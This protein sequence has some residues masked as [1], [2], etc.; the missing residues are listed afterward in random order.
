[1]KKPS[2]FLINSNLTT[3]SDDP[4][5][6][7]EKY[8]EFLKE[9]EIA[10]VIE[11][12]VNLSNKNG[13][14]SWICSNDPGDSHLE[15]LKFAASYCDLEHF[16]DHRNQNVTVDIKSPEPFKLIKL[17]DL[18]GIGNPSAVRDLL[19]ETWSPIAEKLASVVEPEPVKEK[20]KVE[21][22]KEK[23]E[24]PKKEEI[25]PDK[26]EE[27]KDEPV[28]EKEEKKRDDEEDQKDVDLD[29]VDINVGRLR[30]LRD[31]HMFI[32]D[33]RLKTAEYLNFIGPDEPGETP[34]ASKVLPKAIKFITSS[35]LK[36]RVGNKSYPIVVYFMDGKQ[37]DALRLELKSAERPNFILGAIDKNFFEEDEPFAEMQ[38]KVGAKSIGIDPILA[39][40]MN[41]AWL[42][43]TSDV[44]GNPVSAIQ[45]NTYVPLNFFRLLNKKQRPIQIYIGG[46]PEGAGYA[47]TI[48]VLASEHE[49]S[50]FVKLMRQ[51]K[52]PSLFY[53]R[54]SAN[55]DID[56]AFKTSDPEEFT[57]SNV[58][59]LKGEF[60][61]KA[62][63]KNAGKKIKTQI[64]QLHVFAQ[65]VLGNKTKSAGTFLKGRYT[66]GTHIVQF[67]A[68]MDT[69]FVWGSTTQHVKVDT[70]EIMKAMP[71]VKQ[72]I[73]SYL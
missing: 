71:F 67:N 45:A 38:L 37:A 19:H 21:P 43:A 29:V 4:K 33:P 35:R 60:D 61:P 12:S 51:F 40:E 44:S 28:V 73:T 55:S 20:P 7:A 9:D 13:I 52:M 1:M 30:S 57:P 23:K 54:M 72:V 36:H 6:G 62:E 26:K 10:E 2:L 31:P 70:K 18:I 59:I 66:V 27:T 3:Q 5:E 17:K 42:N 58:L 8:K 16:P 56:A 50:Q 15:K 68:E 65:T 25:K 39:A 69:C 46:R 48:Y 32:L 41:R 49:S 24:T 14:H 11:S 53:E 22:K 34:K 47:N 63:V 64:D